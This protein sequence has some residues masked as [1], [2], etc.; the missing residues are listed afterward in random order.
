M[1]DLW[2]TSSLFRWTAYYIQY[3]LLSLA[4]NNFFY[5]AELIKRKTD[6]IFI[7]MLRKQIRHID[8]RQTCFLVY[9][10]N[11]LFQQ[12]KSRHA[13]KTSQA[14]VGNIEIYM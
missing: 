6:C 14:C 4:T 7:S 5:K 1:T 13:C 9:A 11:I 3:I 12:T 8:V 2:P 10:S